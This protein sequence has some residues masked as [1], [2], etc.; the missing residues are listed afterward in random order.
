[1]WSR[2]RSLVSLQLLLLGLAAAATAASSEEP[3]ASPS[4]GDV[5]SALLQSLGEGEALKERGEVPGE[6]DPPSLTAEEG[7]ASNAASNSS[8]AAQTGV[9]ENAL[10]ATASREASNSAEALAAG[11]ASAE[12]DSEGKVPRLVRRPYSEKTGG[13]LKTPQSFM[14]RKFDAEG[15]P[16]PLTE[17]QLEAEIDRLFEMAPEEVDQQTAA[18]AR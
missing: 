4:T 6:T 18:I 8:S 13:F 16:I 2:R 12:A 7:L 11:H 17:E 3:A 5:A 10:F 14:Q 1:M 9:A 15:N